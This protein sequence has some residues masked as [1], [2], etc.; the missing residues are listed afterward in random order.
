MK[1]NINTN[2]RIKRGFTLIELLAV[3]VV[4]AIILVIAIPSIIKIINKSKSDANDNQMGLI[5]NAASKYIVQYGEE[6]SDPKN[7]VV[8]IEKLIEKKLIEV[9]IKNPITNEPYSPGLAVTIKNI[10]NQYVTEV[11]EKYG[12]YVNPEL[13][14][15]MIPVKYDGT[16]WVKADANN[17]NKDWYD[18]ATQKW[19]NAV[20]VLENGIQT[21]SYYQ[22]ANVGTIIEAGDMNTML[23]WIPRY[24][25]K[26]WNAQGTNGTTPSE[27]DVVFERKGDIKS[28][29]STNGTYLTHPAFTFGSNE[30]N[31]MWVGKFETTGAID[32][33]TIKPMTISLTEQSINVFFDS[34][35]AMQN[36]GNAY[37]F[38]ADLN[39]HMMKNT[40]WGAVAYLSNSRYGKYGND[41][42]S[43]VNKEIWPNA[44]Y[45]IVIY[46]HKS[47]CAGGSVVARQQAALQSPYYA[48][49]GLQASTTG[50]IYGIYDMSGGAMEYVMAAQYNSDN[51]TIGLPFT[52]FTSEIVDNANFSKYIDKYNYDV[53]SETDFSRGLLGD[54]TKETSGWN[55]DYTYFFNIG[56]NWLS[57]GGYYTS[58]APAGIFGFNR[59]SGNADYN[60]STRIVITPGS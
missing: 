14:T 27:I 54:A 19:A 57:R 29:G 49:N 47:G 43:G 13:A 10:N 55:G 8:T 34:I 53:N 58:G 12:A 6:V 36:S 16:N 18:Y 1:K 33:I 38:T 39:T 45:F 35:R 37:G 42:Y 50:N 44:C 56:V 20:T 15:G 59:A 3:I 60:M 48:P 51:E 25:Y 41:I 30:L 26:L 24:K 5:K 32:N 28:T 23:V 31:G 21:R 4:L 22:N 52:D 7:A 9:N 17:I 2:R 46:K 40:E 11:Y